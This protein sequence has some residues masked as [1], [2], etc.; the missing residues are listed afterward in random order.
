MTVLEII[1]VLFFL[2]CVSGIIFT[3]GWIVGKDKGFDEGWDRGW[4]CC[5][6]NTMS[7]YELKRKEVDS[8]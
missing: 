7:K 6:D 1:G 5:W 2:A 3:M 4:D 8:E